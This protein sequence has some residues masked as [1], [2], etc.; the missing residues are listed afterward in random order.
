[1]TASHRLGAATGLCGAVLILTGSV[2]L[3]QRA[4]PP[5]P[6]APDNATCLACHEDPS[7]VSAT[8]KRLSVEDKKFGASIH[9]TLGMACVDCHADLKST[10]DFPHPEKLAKVDCSGCHAGDRKS[11]RLNSSY[12]YIS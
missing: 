11:T 5:A 12:G 6:P 3:A 4:R 8:G 9:G 2:V 10:A 1:M 7:L